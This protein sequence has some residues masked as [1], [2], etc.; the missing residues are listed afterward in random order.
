MAPRCTKKCASH[1]HVSKKLGTNVLT[2]QDFPS[3]FDFFNFPTK[4]EFWA[5]FWSIPPMVGLQITALCIPGMYPCYC[6]IHN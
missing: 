5:A 4:Q 3:P 1:K 6:L 2:S